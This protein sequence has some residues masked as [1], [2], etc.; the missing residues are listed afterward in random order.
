MKTNSPKPEN[1][2]RRFAEAHVLGALFISFYVFWF[3]NTKNILFP[4]SSLLFTLFLLRC[5]RLYTWLDNTP[6]PPPPRPRT[7]EER[8]A[9]FLRHQKERNDAFEKIHGFRIEAPHWGAMSRR[10]NGPLK[11]SEPKSQAPLNSKP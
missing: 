8:N 11:K 3:V 4:L 2:L 10:P 5:R 6:P 1:R 9:D 7:M